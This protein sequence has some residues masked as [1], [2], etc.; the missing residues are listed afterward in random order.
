MMRFA[1]AGADVHLVS[2]RADMSGLSVPSKIY[3]IMAAGRPILFIGPGNSEAAMVVREAN[4][5]YTIEP[6]QAVQATEML[7]MYHRDRPL[8][9]QHGR[10]GRAYFDRQCDRRIGTDRFRVLFEE[11]TVS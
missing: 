3:G 10:A 11:L 5:G 1:L 8:A 7:L 4:C 2:L 9:D 6:N